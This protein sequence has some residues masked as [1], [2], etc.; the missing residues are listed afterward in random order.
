MATVIFDDVGIA[1]DA[2]QGARVM[3][4]ADENPATALP[5]SCRFANCG[6]CRVEVVEG[7][8][9]CEPPTER[10]ARV[11]RIFS[12]GDTV[13]LACQLRVR[14]GDGRVRLRVML[15]RSL[16]PRG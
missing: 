8:E 3:D 12:D 14:A 4:L 11:K 10:E 5:F 13:R 9:L 15:R 2:P 1:L 7:L 16:P 6:T